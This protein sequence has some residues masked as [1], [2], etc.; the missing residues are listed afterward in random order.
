MPKKRRVRTLRD[1]E[2]VKGPEKLH[3]SARLYFSHIFWTLWN[4]ISS[5][6]SVLVVS[7][8]LRLFVNILT[9]VDNYSFSVKTSVQ[10]NQFKRNYLPTKKYFFNFFL[11]FQNLHKIWNTLK[12]KIIL[13]G[14]FF[15][16]LYTAKRR[17]V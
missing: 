9:S 8:I 10:R 14:Y 13:R 4:K 16:K 3:I 15:L 6:N 11:P 2:P 12:Q 5:K 1:S 7:E 17:V